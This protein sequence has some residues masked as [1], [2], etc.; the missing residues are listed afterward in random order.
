MDKLSAALDQFSVS[1]GLFY[2]GELCGSNTFGR[3][4][5]DK[6][7]L[8]FLDQGSAQLQIR[9]QASRTVNGPAVIFF[10]G[11]CLYSLSASAVDKPK[12]VC[13]NIQYGTGAPN[14]VTASLPELLIVSR[15]AVS[16]LQAV[17]ELLVDEAFSERDAR[18]AMIN[19]LMEMVVICLI[20]HVIDKRL[21]NRGMLAGLAHPRLCRVILAIHAAPQRNWSVEELAELAAMSRSKFS[22]LFHDWVGMPVG[23]YVQCWRVTIAQEYLTLGKPV[24]WVAS[25]VGYETS[26]AFAKMFRKKTGCSPRTWL[27]SL[28]D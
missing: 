14:P 16:G 1:A 25:A 21:V 20:R 4:N 24:D 10:P 6:G 2:A 13:A 9:D 18:I 19:R 12:I 22:K 3:D 26:S 8:H 15:E 5:V 28:N 7:H 23:E 27:K 17:A 11:P